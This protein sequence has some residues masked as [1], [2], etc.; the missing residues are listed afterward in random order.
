M[1]DIFKHDVYCT[2]YAFFYFADSVIKVENGN[3]SWGG[4]AAV[5]KK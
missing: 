3:F 1:Y 4:D 2:N 5:L